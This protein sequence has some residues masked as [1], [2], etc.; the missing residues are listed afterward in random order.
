VQVIM[1]VLV[2]VFP[3]MVMHYKGPVIDPSTVTITV[4]QLPTLGAP[5]GVGGAP[6][7]GAPNLGAPVLNPPVVEP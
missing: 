5:G 6:A 1:I 4:P 3:Q 7:L 2:I